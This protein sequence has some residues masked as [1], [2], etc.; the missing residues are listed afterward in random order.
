M[1]SH[2]SNLMKNHCLN[3]M[4]NCVKVCSCLLILKMN[5]VKE[6]SFRSNVKAQASCCV[7]ELNK[8]LNGQVVSWYYFEEP[9]NFRL[10]V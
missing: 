10:N 4:K 3:L 7:E 9:G 1:M 5:Y 2:C 6:Y 8:Y